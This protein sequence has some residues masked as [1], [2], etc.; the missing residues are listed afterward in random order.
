MN[1]D[2]TLRPALVV[3]AAMS[4]LTGIVYPLAIAAIGRVALPRAAAGSLVERDGKLVGSSLIGQS[5]TAPGH[6]WGR[7]S[8]TSPQP[9]NALASGG[10]NLG[11]LNPAL[12]EAVKARV[13]AL[14]RA[15]REAGVTNDGPVPIDLATASA[16]GLDPHISPE[17]ARWQAAR[18]AKVSGIPRERIDALIAAHTEGPGSRLPRH[19][20]RRRAR[21]QPRDR[22]RARRSRVALS[23]RAARDSACRRAGPTGRERDRNDLAMRNACVTARGRSGPDGRAAVA[24]TGPSGTGGRPRGSARR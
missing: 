23:R 5:F 2:R 18:V 20:A 22:R 19:A 24:R 14:R 12:V 3:L 8:A 21:A 6:F 9:D 10:S 7:P 17:A 11:P 13:D 1:I 16:S 4:L 15:D